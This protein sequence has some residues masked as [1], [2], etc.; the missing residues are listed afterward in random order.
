MHTAMDVGIVALIV[1]DNGVNH[2]PGLLRCGS[3]VQINQLVPVNFLLK[4]GKIGA[5]FSTSNPEPISLSTAWLEFSN[6]DNV[7]LA[8]IVIPLPASFVPSC[9]DLSG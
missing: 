1:A 4:D 2:C 8:A 7:D 5:N 6:D 9:Q 3:T